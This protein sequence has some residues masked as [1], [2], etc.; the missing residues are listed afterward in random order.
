MRKLFII[1]GVLVL[2]VIAIAFFRLRD[3]NFFG[4]AS[5]QEITINEVTYSVS[6]A[7]S[8]EEKQVGLSDRENLGD[9]DGM[10]F[11]C[12]EKD[13]YQ[14]WMRNMNFPID[15]IY[16]SDNTVVDVIENAQPPEDENATPEVYT[17]DEPANYVLELKAGQAERAGIE[18]GNTITLPNL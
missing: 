17:P 10:L 3:F 2:A 18:V 15:I 1:Y 9:N 11:V 16:I 12:D 4:G 14:F 8:P 6:I 7:R 5:E 13:R